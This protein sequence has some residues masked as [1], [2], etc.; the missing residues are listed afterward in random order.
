MFLYAIKGKIYC[1]PTSHKTEHIGN[2]VALCISASFEREWKS[3][4]PPN[5]IKCAEAVA[6][7]F[8]V[9][10]AR[11][12]LISNWLIDWYGIGFGFE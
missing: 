3:N 9:R 4:E 10:F 8:A 11:F 6:H 2:V 5:Q 7:A 1:Q 12:K